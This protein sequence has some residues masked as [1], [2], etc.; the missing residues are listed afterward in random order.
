MLRRYV[1]A[2]IAVP[3]LLLGIGCQSEEELKKVEQQVGDMKV[4]IFK[5]R[6][7]MEEANKAAAAEYVAANEGRNLDRRFQAD[8]QD[9]LRQLKDSTR[10]LNNRLGD[11]PRS[12]AKAS[13][14]LDTQPSA[15]SEDEKALNSVL[16]DY[17]RGNYSLAAESLELFL[18]SYPSSGKRPDAFFYLGLS[19][20]NQKTYDKAQVA[21]DTILKNYTSANQFLPAK[22]KRGQCLLRQGLKPAAI[23]NFKEIIRD[24][25]NTSEARTSQQELSD[26]GL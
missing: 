10:A 14:V 26:L 15:S 22:L 12:S 6:M 25:P 7:Q 5:L 1:M 16:L 2:G 17:N 18:K 21:F 8:L 4:E 19:Y 20:Y 13:A 11:A 3:A 24:F 23:S 9:T